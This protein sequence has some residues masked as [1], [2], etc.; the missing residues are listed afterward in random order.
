MATATMNLRHQDYTV[1]WLCVLPLDTAAAEAMLADKHPNSPTNPND[2]N[3][4]ILGRIYDHNV[5]IA[6]LRSGVYGT[7]S[8]AILAKQM[9]STFQSIRFFLMVGIGGGAP[10][11]TADIRLGDVVVSNQQGTSEKSYNMIMAK[12]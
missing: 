1:A 3:K 12:Q 7:T 6:C 8:A 10:S 5:V 9:Q 4:Y 2:D 11:E